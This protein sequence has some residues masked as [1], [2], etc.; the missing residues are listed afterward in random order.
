M[1]GP[2]THRAR[3]AGDSS[4][5]AGIGGKT[6][7]PSTTGQRW[8][9]AQVPDQQGRTVVITGANTGLGFEAAKVLAQHD[10]TVV[11]ACRNPHKA[12][13]AAARIGTA[14]PA[15][16][17]STLQ[18]D[19]ASLA[20][21]RRAAEQLRADYRRIDLLINNAGAMMPRHRL[22]EDGFELTLATNHLGPF[23]FTGLILDRLLAVPGSRIV[24][25][26]SNGHRRGTINFDDL[27]FQRGYRHQTAYFQSK[28]ANLLFT[29]ELQR[30][31]AAAGA[32]TIAVAAHPGN[33][34]TEFG[35]ELSPLV[36][37]AMSP[38][39]RMLTWWLMQSPQMGALATVRAAVDPDARG[40]DY[41]GPPGR[42]QFTG[43]PTRVESTARSHDPQ[44]QRRL[45]HESEQLTGVTY[46]VGEPVHP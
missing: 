29:Y 23:A 25:V 38:R 4:V 26:A 1:V 20:S 46:P 42:A 8:T 40:G 27:H 39:L 7:R 28:L 15:A 32:P 33:A 34:R 36:R 43:Y 24:T 5:D 41:Y 45:W 37:V 16:K 9:S 17:V 31:L 14:A 30:R 12:A 2:V 10:A 6:M 3:S 13:D 35:R 18:L 21:V 44:A 22:T 19:L 11:L